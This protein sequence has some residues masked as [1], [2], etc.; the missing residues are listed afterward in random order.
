VVR[1]TGLIEKELKENFSKTVLYLRLS[2][3]CASNYTVN[4]QL[5]GNV[6]Q[7]C[8]ICDK[9]GSVSSNEKKC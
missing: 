4:I 2:A 3:V 1:G 7:W 6:A 9:R 5:Q 8:S